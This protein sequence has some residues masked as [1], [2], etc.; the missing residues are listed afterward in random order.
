MKVNAV[1]TLR[2]KL[3]MKGY[4]LLKRTESDSMGSKLTAFLSLD[5]VGKVVSSSSDY[6]WGVEERGLEVKNSDGS[7]TIMHP[8]KGFKKS[9][10]GRDYLNICYEF[11]DGVA[12]HTDGSAE[13]REFCEHLAIALSARLFKV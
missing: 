7:I 4:F 10:G 9:G 12:I 6:E 3:F 2:R 13:S 5:E 1:R 8:R 11:Y